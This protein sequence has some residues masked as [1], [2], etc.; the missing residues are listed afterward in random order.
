MLLLNHP[1]QL[2]FFQDTCIYFIRIAKLY[3]CIVLFKIRNGYVKYA[4]CGPI[5]FKLSKT[6][7][8]M[9]NITHFI[10]CKQ[11]SIKYCEGYRVLS[12]KYSVFHVSYV[13]VF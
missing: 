10:L 1:E 11:I 6:Q 2:F 8:M 4:H 7:L 5:H 12:R 9:L 13:F 3:T